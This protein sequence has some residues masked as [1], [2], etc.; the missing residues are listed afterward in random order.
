MCCAASGLPIRPGARSAMAGLGPVLGAFCKQLVS[1][2]EPLPWVA[3][4]IGAG[5]QALEPVSQLFANVE[6]LSLC[7]SVHPSVHLRCGGGAWSLLPDQEMSVEILEWRKLWGEVFVLKTGSN[8]D[9][10]VRLG[11]REV[12]AMTPGPGAGSS[13]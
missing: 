10:R 7:L 6:S 9:I 4:V 2:A 8:R 11:S 13:L 3:S 1:P 12:W 5:C